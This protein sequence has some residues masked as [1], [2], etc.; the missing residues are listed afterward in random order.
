MSARRTTSASVRSVAVTSLIVGARSA[1]A[2]AVLLFDFQGRGRPSS[3][4]RRDC[5]N[6]GIPREPLSEVAHAF[7]ALCRSAT[8]SPRA[9]LLRHM[10]D[11]RLPDEAR[12]HAGSTYVTTPPDGQAELA[13]LDTPAL[14]AI[15]EDTR[16]AVRTRV[17]LCPTACP[18][19]PQLPMGKPNQ[20]G[21]IIRGAGVRVPPPASS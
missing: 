14:R 2:A 15:C 18:T 8:R 17:R 1:Y 9:P 7:P 21:I 13:G 19:R 12:A 5:R 20:S 3:S 10:F 4:R 16:N 11:H 6:A